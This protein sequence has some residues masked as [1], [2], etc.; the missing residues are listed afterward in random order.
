MLILHYSFDNYYYT[1]ILVLNQFENNEAKEKQM[2]RLNVYG[3][4][5][6]Q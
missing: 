5:C 4:S 1:S 2:N 6:D 3:A